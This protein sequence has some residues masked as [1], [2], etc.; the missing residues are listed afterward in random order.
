MIQQ[1]KF[2]LRKFEML[3]GKLVKLFLLK[4]RDFVEYKQLRSSG[5][6]PSDRLQSLGSRET[7]ELNPENELGNNRL[8]DS[9]SGPV[10]CRVSI[11]C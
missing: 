3:S 6:A 2:E 4:F 8:M 7:N 10:F 9:G 11:G 5:S 1:K